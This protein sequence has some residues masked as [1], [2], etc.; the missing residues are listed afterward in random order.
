SASL[1]PNVPDSLT[2]A[3]H[4]VERGF[5]VGLHLN[6]VE[7]YPLSKSGDVASLLGS[8]GMFY[9]VTKLFTLLDEGVVQKEHIEREVR[10]QIEWCFDQGFT[11]THVSGNWD[12]HVHPAIAAVLTPLMLRYGIRFVRI[13]CEEPLP[14]FGFEIP[15]LQLAEIRSINAIAKAARPIFEAEGI[16][17]TDHFRGHTL[18]GN[19]SAKNLRHILARLPEGTTELMVHP[20]SQSSYGT[21]FDLDPQRQTEL[22]MLMDESLKADLAERKIALVSY[23]DL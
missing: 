6:L 9:G 22:N 17:F 1:W 23:G 12:A 18:L 20:G 4:A 3:K 5:P 15:E 14:P 8:T 19:A 11:P 21:P 2:A 10:A 16:G 13:P 7:E